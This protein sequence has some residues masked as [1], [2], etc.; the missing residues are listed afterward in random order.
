M[1]RPRIAEE[2]I[3]ADLGKVLCKL[4]ELQDAQIRAAMAPKETAVTLTDAE[5]VAALELLKDPRLFDRILEDFGRCGVVGEEVNKLMGYLAAVS[6]KLDDPLAVVIQSSSAAGKSSLMEAVL[7]F[8][9]EEERVK[10][11]AM[12]GQSLFYMGETNLKHKILAIVEEEGASR[13]SYA[14]KILQSEGEL[15]IAELVNEFGP[16]VKIVL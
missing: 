6:R 13:A 16:R 11:A 10:Y 1:A 2:V 9:P 15:T 5:T 3:K 7:A 12:T 14:L 8:M 4:E